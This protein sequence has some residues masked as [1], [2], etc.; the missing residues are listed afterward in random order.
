M[1]PIILIIIFIVLGIFIITS[2]ILG[3][4]FGT[5]VFGNNPKTTPPPTTTTA[6]VPIDGTWSDWVQSGDCNKICGGG[7]I[8]FSRICN[9]PRN[10]GADCVGISTKT[11]QCN[12]SNCDTYHRS[13]DK[14][15]CYYHDGNDLSWYGGAPCDNKSNTQKL[16]YNPNNLTLSNFLKRTMCLT[17]DNK[18]K[19]CD[20]TDV[21][22]QWDLFGDR[23][24]NKSNKSFYITAT[25]L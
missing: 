10:G 20:P 7:T 14:K 25:K 13:S 24:Y 12:I 23:L 22:Q 18:M 6:P 1:D 4:Y 8:N 2:I 16:V 3:L 15:T 9:P 5:N 21:S 17:K 19:K 11:E